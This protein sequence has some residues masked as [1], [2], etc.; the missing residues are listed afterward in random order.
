M[1][2]DIFSGKKIIFGV[3]GGIAAYKSCF[4]VRELAKRNAEVRVVMTPSAVE[5][6]SPLTFSTLSNYNVVVDTFP[7]TQKDG[8]NTSTWH[9]EYAMWAD[10]MIIAPATINTIAK[11]AHGF[12]DNALTT[13][14]SALRSPLLVAPAADVDMYK[15]KFTQENINRL[16]SNDAYIVKAESGELA[17]GLSGYGRMADVNKIIDAAEIV[18]SGLK[19]D[20]PGKKILI[21]AGPTYEDIDPVRFIGNRSSGKMGYAIAKAA[22]LRGADVTLISGPTLLTAYPE[23]KIISVRSAAEMKKSVE[24]ELR[25]NDILIMAAAVADFRPLTLKSRKIKKEDKLT[26]I[27][28]TRT[29]DILASIKKDGKIIVGFALETDNEKSNAVK[30]LKAKNL[31]MIVINSVRD[32]KSAFEYD[33]NKIIVI[34]NTGKQKL[35]PLLSKFQAANKILSEIISA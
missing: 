24:K 21:T 5:F 32:K 20:L 35:Y 18:L 11:V 12:A 4:L 16:E 33:T 6:I 14:A 23:I 13:L 31:D 3:T 10:L 34:H 15:N 22:F 1:H 27:K 2:N 17:S 7:A 19:K 28:L 29:D 30:K 8:T 25:N 26:E 9:I